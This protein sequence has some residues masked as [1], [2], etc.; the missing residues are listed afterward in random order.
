MSHA[1]LSRLMSDINEVS[2][3]RN[4]RDKSERMFNLTKS[5]ISHVFARYTKTK[6]MTNNKKLVHLEMKVLSNLK[7]LHANNVGSLTPSERADVLY[8]YHPLQPIADLMNKP[9][10]KSSNSSGS[11]LS[12]TS[13]PSITVTFDKNKELAVAS[14]PVI[15]PPAKSSRSSLST[16]STRLTTVT[17]DKNKEVAV[18]SAPV[19]RPPAKSS[20]T[21][22]RSRSKSPGSRSNGGRRRSRRNK[23]R[24]NQKP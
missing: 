20:R 5:D 10:V 21:R 1:D 12:T 18:A 3:N 22:S 9:S 15:R 11:G 13:K 23:T 14:A 24:R 19:I 2:T 6:E 16:T 7:K 17:Y 4:R 8:K